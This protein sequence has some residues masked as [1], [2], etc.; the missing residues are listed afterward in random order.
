MRL[1]VFDIDGTL[2]LGGGLGTHCFFTAFE[3]VFGVRDLDRSLA[4]YEHSTDCGIGREAATRVLGRLPTGIEMA[5][6]KEAYLARLQDEIGRTASAYR[7]VPGAER[8]LDR[9]GEAGRRWRVAI[10]T[11]NWRRAA[12][13]KLASA[14]VSQPGAA[15]CS[16]DGDSRA[17]VLAT[18]VRRAAELAGV[19]AFERVVYVG[20]QPWDLE[21]ARIV[22]TG[23]VG[24]GSEERGSRL[25]ARGASVVAGYED[26][27]FFLEVLEAAAD[28]AAPAAATFTM[29]APMS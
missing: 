21:A 16:E 18:A 20:D 29:P 17:G 5:A 9:I 11:G 23:F 7:P 3:E 13:L 14:G 28:A 22:G 19:A 15:A 4:G 27:A 25:R 6:F 2:T 24:I 10:A 8:V 12:V 26:L 1:A